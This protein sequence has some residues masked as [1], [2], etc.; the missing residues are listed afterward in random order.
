MRAPAGWSP[1]AAMSELSRW[2]RLGLAVLC[3]ALMTAG[4]PP[5]GIPWLMFVAMPVLVWLVH[6]APSARSAAW[7]GWAAG[8][9]YFVTGL[10]WIGNAFLVDPDKFL[11]LLPLGVVGLP[12]GLALFWAL[13]FWAAKRCWARTA[14]GGA[15]VLSVMLSAVELARGYVLTG[16]PWALPAYVWLDTPV[17]QAASW[18]GPFGLT[19][20]TLFLTSLPLTALAERRI[21]PALVPSAL[22][23]AL[24]TWGD[25]RT[26][27]DMTVSP[28]RPLMRLVQPNAPQHLKWEPGYR[29][30][31]YQR[32]LDATSAP[33]DVPGE[34]PDLV[35]WPEMAV[36][37][38]PGENPAEVARISQA[39]GGAPVI[40]GAF[41]REQRAEGEFL[42]NA[43]HTILPGGTLGPRYDKHHLVPFGEYMPL[44]DLLG[45]LGLPD[46]SKGV[47]FSRGEGPRTLELPGLP[48]FSPII[49]YEAIFPYEAVGPER[50]GW[51][52]QITNDA[53]FGS[54]A[55][56]QQHLAQA[57]FRAVEQGLPVVRATNT[58]ISAMID[59]YGRMV[60]KIEMHNFDRLDVRLPDALPP[61]LYSIVGDISCI[62]LVIGM[63]FFTIFRHRLFHFD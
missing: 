60:A 42:T 63:V 45:Q 52:A 32:A 24:W 20:I 22:L 44:V 8:F 30:E 36:F 19:V 51:I 34:D 6:G 57:R 61:T 56:P 25:F 23:V 35:I 50:P 53:W 39:A 17:M 49:C 2:Q 12:A 21:A 10:H 14:W 18:A 48:S 5:V 16:F 58:G 27:T 54:F 28:D 26:P 46:F 7:T 3:G 4:H 37:F 43:F 33:P 29:E 9:G 31:F 40:L 38:V 11:L 47:G 41:H 55:G 1:V 13:A 15:L 62:L 59:S